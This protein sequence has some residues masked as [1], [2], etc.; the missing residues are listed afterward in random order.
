M[1]FFL[2]G[3]M[4]TLIFSLN[5]SYSSPET[6]PS[7]SALF[8]GEG[9][10]L[11]LND[12]TKAFAKS[13]I[14]GASE[15]IYEQLNAPRKGLSEDS[16]LKKTVKDFSNSMKQT[17]SE[18][19]NEL[20]NAA[21]SN[22]G[23][24][25]D[26]VRSYGTDKIAKYGV[27]MAGGIT[28]IGTTGYF[29]KKWWGQFVKTLYKPKLKLEK[30]VGTGDASIYKVFLN[31]DADAELQ[32]AIAILNNSHE[33]SE[34]PNLLFYGPPGTGK[35]IKA[36]QMAQD[37]GYVKCSGSDWFKLP[38]EQAIEEIDKLFNTVAKAKQKTMIFIDEADSLLMNR[39]ALSPEQSKIV[40][41][42][43]TK[44]GDLNSHYFFVFATNRADKIDLAMISRITYMVRFDLPDVK[45][46]EMLFEQYLIDSVNSIS[47]LKS[48]EQVKLWVENNLK[49]WASLSEGF[50]GRD[51]KS[52]ALRLKWKLLSLKT[53]MSEDL[54]G[55]MMK[56][57]DNVKVKR[58][59]LPDDI[60]SDR[61]VDK[62]IAPLADAA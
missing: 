9:D 20:T 3:L 52:I 43:L 36:R 37:F 58:S 38:T 11:R 42:F 45:T 4:I 7:L 34:L 1:R 8:G 55:F 2:I 44:T 59:D 47:N 40:T 22:L 31:A 50:S 51:I 23:K 28:L 57:F 14:E 54:D 24:I 18:G 13:F 53:P 12:M 21:T 61:L 32:E 10:D 60:K 5:L 29:A 19:V 49:S 46:R 27:A 26:T 62:K 41:H 6:S 25:G 16:F 15:G 30:G 33:Q 17:L 56:V 35:T 48:S 39:N